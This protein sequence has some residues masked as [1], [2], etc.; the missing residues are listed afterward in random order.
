MMKH[1]KLYEEIFIKLD[2]LEFEG[3]RAFKLDKDDGRLYRTV[4]SSGEYFLTH[5]DYTKL[6]GLNDSITKKIKLLE[7][8]KKTTID[9]FRLAIKKVIKDRKMNATIKKFNI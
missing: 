2:M 7:E 8:Q 4:E 5:D 9:V 1:V 6:E 3:I